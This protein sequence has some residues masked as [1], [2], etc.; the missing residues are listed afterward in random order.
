[1]KLQGVKSQSFGLNPSN[2]L[3]ACI[4]KAGLEGANIKPLRELIGELYPYRYM[5]ML[6]DYKKVHGV[7]ITE[8][9]GQVPTIRKVLSPY[10]QEKYDAHKHRTYGD[11]WRDYYLDAEGEKIW[12]AHAFEDVVG[13]TI[14]FKDLKGRKFKDIIE[15]LTSSLKRIKAQQSPLERGLDEFNIGLPQYGRILTPQEF[16]SINHACFAD[17]RIY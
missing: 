17:K 13:G 2:T 8:T 9:C 4:V 14:L 7:N 1:M 15:T 6:G 10:W 5:E 3:R 12:E 16:K 11:R